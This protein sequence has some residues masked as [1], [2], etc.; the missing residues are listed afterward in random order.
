MRRIERSEQAL[1]TRSQPGVSPSTT[2]RSAMMSRT[3][4]STHWHRISHRSA[5]RSV[6]I[7]LLALAFIGVAADHVSAQFVVYDAA[8]TARN[9]VTATLKEYLYRTQVQQ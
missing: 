5:P 4:A 6:G 3:S 7:F 2:R 1:V 8:T 9:A